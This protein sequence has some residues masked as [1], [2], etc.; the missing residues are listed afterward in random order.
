MVQ[1]TPGT[2]T[3][4]PLQQSSSSWSFP[5]RDVNHAPKAVQTESSVD[6]ESARMPNILELLNSAAKDPVKGFISTK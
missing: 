1:I 2:V 5:F 4:V 3:I 6:L